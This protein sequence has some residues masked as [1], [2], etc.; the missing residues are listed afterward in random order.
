MSVPGYNYAEK[1]WTPRPTRADGDCFFHAVFGEKTGTDEIYFDKHAPFRRVYWAAFLTFYTNESMSVKLQEIIQKCFVANDVS[2]ASLNYLPEYASSV[3]RP[4]YWVL[5]EEIPILCTLWNVTVVLFL[6]ERERPLVFEPNPQISYGF[7]LGHPIQKREQVIRL[8]NNHFERLIV[9]QEQEMEEASDS[10]AE[11]CELESETDEDLVEIESVYLQKK[12]HRKKGSAGFQGGQYQIT[13]LTM[14]LLNA[15][16]KVKI[17]V[18][19]TENDEA[20]KFDDLVFESPEGDVLLQA[21]H[22]EGRNKIIK[23]EALMSTSTNGDFSLP[24]YYV[25]FQELKSKFNLRNVVICTN[26][27]LQ[28]DKKMLGL[29]SRRTATEDSLLRLQDKEVSF[30]TG[31]HFYAFNVDDENSKSFISEFKEQIKSFH[32]ENMPDTKLCIADEDVKEFLRRLQFFVHYLDKAS[33]DTFVDDLIAS[34]TLANNLDTRE[35]F[36]AVNKLIENWF[37]APDGVYISHLD[38]RSMLFDIRTNKYCESLQLYEI[39]FQNNKLSCFEGRIL[40]VVTGQSMLNIVK[41]YQ[42][43]RMEKVK[44]LFLSSEDDANILKEGIR[45]FSIPRYAFLVIAHPVK[46]K[47]QTLDRLCGKIT[48]I[49]DDFKHKKLVLVAGEQDK[50]VQRIKFLNVSGYEEVKQQIGFEDLTEQ[51]Q[52]NLRRRRNIAF[53]G[54]NLTLEELLGHDISDYVDGETLASLAKNERI[55]IGAAVKH[56]DADADIHTY[57]IERNLKRAEHNVPEA[58]LRNLKDLKDRIVL[59]SDSAG[60]GKTT[61]LTNLAV[62]IKEDHPTLWVIRIDLNSHSNTL[63]QASK[64]RSMTVSVVDLLNGQEVTK[65]DGEFVK[66]LFHKKDKVVLMLDAVD[67]VNG[68]YMELVMGMITEIKTQMNFKK[69]F[70]TTRPHL[71]EE[72]QEALQVGA[73]SLEPF[74]K[75]NQEDFL[76]KYWTQKL[77]LCGETQQDRCQLFARVLID[78]MSRWINESSENT[79]AGIPLQTRML[80]EVFQQRNQ[81][82]SDQTNHW[83]R[84]KEFLSSDKDEPRLPQRIN[85]IQLYELFIEKKRDIFMTK[86][87]TVGNAISEKAAMDKFEECHEYHRTLALPI[88]FYWDEC[89]RFRCFGIMENFS[90]AFVEDFVLRAGIVQRVEG[91]INFIHRTFAEYFAAQSLLLELQQGSLSGVFKEFLLDEV[92]IRAE[93]NVVRLFFDRFVQ[94]DLQSIPDDTLLAFSE[95]NYLSILS[96]IGTSFLHLL[97]GEGSAGTIDFFL[98]CTNFGITKERDAI[99]VHTTDKECNTPLH[100]ACARGHLGVV[101]ALIRRGVD[102]NFQNVNGETPLHVAALGGYL[103]VVEYLVNEA[104]ADLNKL[105]AYGES[106]LYCAARN[107]HLPV[108]K[109]FVEHNVDYTGRYDTALHAACRLNNL[110]MVEYL[111]EEAGADVNILDENQCTPLHAAAHEGNLDIVQFL[112]ENDC[113]M[114]I[115]NSAGDT[116]FHDAAMRGFMKVVAFLVENGADVT[117]EDNDGYNIVEL[118]QWL[119]QTEEKGSEE[120]SNQEND[121]SEKNEDSTSEV[122][123]EGD[124]R[125]EGTSSENEEDENKT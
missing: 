83:E 23:Y 56:S 38:A 54:R 15:V 31:G 109:F 117:V 104:D 1:T 86:G 97:A 18:L 58:R 68:S 13:L 10:E 93:F 90:E 22:K 72:L 74:T 7:P 110:D 52:V 32:M 91:K 65:L 96:N 37:V 19:S 39:S 121:E 114:N 42:A 120:E 53:Q 3:V 111:V 66:K 41:L 11:L 55:Q 113:E 49:L 124:E 85:L 26:A 125:E 33:V 112:V 118:L 62:G 20:G 14:V 34:I 59:I 64:N 47:Q 25:S 89:Q 76:T 60:M 2:P 17:W 43:L 107:G 82:D 8:T 87:N 24:K 105:N 46:A 57:Y 6:G 78:K 67:E 115:V 30:K 12:K 4:Q 95:I 44:A 16:R 50:M 102:I 71:C 45:V 101:A 123:S 99:L 103:E 84:C 73:F 98:A 92:L 119:L 29:L 9:V 69:I 88:I 81:A 70:I 28:T 36:D 35:T 106:V 40:H 61:I 21:K 80:A 108:V 77:S 5:V 122:E 94:K 79:F 75:D 100:E 63:K 27:G 51:A 48:K 116:A